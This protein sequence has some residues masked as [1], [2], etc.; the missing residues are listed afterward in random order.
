MILSTAATEAQPSLIQ[1]RDLMRC[2]SRL[3]EVFEWE[4]WRPV[5]PDGAEAEVLFIHGSRLGCFRSAASDEAKVQGCLAIPLAFGDFV[6]RV[7][8]DP[9]GAPSRRR[10]E[11]ELYFFPDGTDR[12]RDLWSGRLEEDPRDPS[13]ARAPLRLGPAA[14]D[15]SRDVLLRRFETC[16]DQ[17]DDPIA[18]PICLGVQL[19]DCAL[20]R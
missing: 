13:G 8:A 14:G 9:P 17:S 6:V 10:M 11:L 15:L 16:R 12:R 7:D 2:T 5:E 19:I 1:Y 4:G 3:D 18:Y 20:R